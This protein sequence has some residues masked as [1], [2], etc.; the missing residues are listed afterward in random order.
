MAGRQFTVSLKVE[1]NDPSVSAPASDTESFELSIVD[2]CADTV[3]IFEPSL[4]DLELS[5]GGGLQ[6]QALSLSDTYSES[7][8]DSGYCGAL[9]YST[10]LSTLSTLF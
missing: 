6:K 9:T 2:Y 7:I 4:I 5:V 8:L 10:D 3:P 1:Q